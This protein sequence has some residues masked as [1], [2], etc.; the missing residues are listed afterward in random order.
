MEN[1]LENAMQMQYTP[2]ADASRNLSMTNDRSQ[3]ESLFA[4]CLPQLRNTAFRMMN[5]RED[6][7][8]ALQDA[9]FLGFRNLHQFRGHVKFSTWMHSILV[10][11][12]RT[13]RRRRISR[14]MTT[15]IDDELARI[16]FSL[17]PADFHHFGP[18]P[19]EACSRE[20]Q[21]RIISQLV[22][23][24][25]SLYREAVWLREIEGLPMQDIADRLGICLSAVKTRLHRGYHMTEQKARKLGI[26]SL[27][28]A[29]TPK[30]VKPNEH[31]MEMHSH[32]NMVENAVAAI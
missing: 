2:E 18:S 11:S 31:T 26:S 19:E 25:P 3:L 16:D 32:S 7:E 15:S 24:L 21:R 14:P 6:C 8:D 10:N 1:I 29:R 27:R 23:A 17:I 30:K 20:E 4:S 22:R 28:P 9:L 12:V 13:I 5:N